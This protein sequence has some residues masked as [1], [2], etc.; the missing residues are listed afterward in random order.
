MKNPPANFTMWSVHCITTQLEIYGKYK[1]NGSYELELQIPH[2]VRPKIQAE[3]VLRREA[4][5]NRENTPFAVRMEENNDSGGRGLSGPCPHTA[6][7]PVQ[8]CRVQR[9]GLLEGKK[10][11][12]VVRTL[13]RV[14]VQ[15][16]EQGI[17]VSRL[18]C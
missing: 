11:P 14:E 6:G 7:N 5:G 10:Q 1:N 4:A 12:A 18:L 9:G 13:S 8:V 16:Q 3:G 15:I 2:S 17:L